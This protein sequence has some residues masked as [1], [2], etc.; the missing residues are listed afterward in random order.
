M[1]ATQTTAAKLVQFVNKRPGLEFAEYGDVKLYR[2]EMREITNDRSDFF[3][4]Y[5][6]ASRR[7]GNEFEAKLTET[8]KTGSGRLTLKENGELEYCTGQYLPTEY[9]PAANRVLVGLI[10][11]DYSNEKDQNGNDVYADGQS[12]CKA[13]KRNLSRR[14]GRL[15]FK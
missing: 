4:L 13:I 10:W 5:A 11:A 12:V 9:R 2:S 7:L 8:L 6:L 3:E 1:K 15:Y 14:V